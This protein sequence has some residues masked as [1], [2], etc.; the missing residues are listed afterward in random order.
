MLAAA[1]ATL[2]VPRGEFERVTKDFPRLVAHTI[3]EGD[4]LAALSRAVGVDRELALTEV[5]DAVTRAPVSS[6]HPGAHVL[7]ATPGLR[8]TAVVPGTYKA[9]AVDQQGGRIDQGLAALK[10]LALS[11]IRGFVARADVI[12][13]VLLIGAAFGVIL[14]TGA[15]D[16]ALG[17]VVTR[18]GEGR[19][20]MLVI[21]VSMTLFS[22]GGAIFGMGE[23]TIA[24]VLVTI[25]LAIRLG[26]DTITGV[27]MCYLATQIG[28]AGAFFNPFTVGIA[29]SIAELPHLSGL[30]F[31]V[32]TWVIVTG[33]G[34]C[35][36]A[37]WAKRVRAD[38]R[39]SP[40]YSLD[41][42]WRGRLQTNSGETS[43]PLKV[44]EV[45]VVLT[46][47]ATLLLSGLG[48]ALWGWYI[49]EMAALFVVAGVFAGLIGGFRPPRLAQ[50]F[51][52]GASSMIEP[53]LVI[54]LSAGIL[55]VL[56]DG[57]VL[58]TVLHA[59][60]A[61]LEALPK[62]VAAPL[63][64]AGQAVINF[65]VPSGSGQ[66]AMT[67][68]VTTPL[69]DILGL[70][71][72]VG[73]LAFQFGDGFGNTVVPTSAVL[74]GVLGA[75][76]IPWT[77]WVRWVWPLVLLLHVVGALLLVVAIYGPEAWMIWPT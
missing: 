19:L 9:I 59:L 69:C 20:R 32:I 38:P 13:F 8:R 12:G 68:P 1:V 76:R 65:F 28:F 15:I 75:A 56:Q 24:F 40:T 57:Q 29:Q 44:S 46:T 54:A 66:A 67:M 4:D 74:M 62:P 22:L 42:H 2:I 51:S 71:R 30:G 52:A 14:G 26:Y 49:E 3:R 25:P 47:F 48:V 34:I 72:Q 7:V 64:M 45:G 41:E 53:A 33:I 21:P 55:Q 27:C 70:Q 16:R 18:L 11:P 61:P 23:S 35:F 36:V 17:R 31:R 63:I 39:R 37:L 58:D 77:A 6:L 43:K 73:V 60:A 10:S 50:E 5:V